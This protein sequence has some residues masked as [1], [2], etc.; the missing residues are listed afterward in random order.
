MVKS[1][2]NGVMALATSRTGK[3]EAARQVRA[4]SES[5]GKARKRR[6]RPL[7]LATQVFIGLFLGL[8]TGVFLGEAAAPLRLVGDAFLRLL[9]I[10]V[11]PYIV[12]VLITGLGRLTYNQV[13]K[14]AFGG[15]SVLLLLWAI[16]IIL[17][18]S[19]PLSFPDWPARSLFQRSSIEPVQ[20]V[21][22]LLLYIPS[23]PFFSL[24]NA[25]VPAIVVFSILIGLALIG[26]PQK[27]ALLEPLQAASETLTRV[28][29]FVA[30]LAPLGVFALI[31]S[32]AGTMRFEDLGRLQVFLVVIALLALIVAL[33][34]LPA[35][36]SS[37]TS[38]RYVDILRELRTPMITAFATGSSLVVLPLLAETCKRMVSEDKQITVTEDAA[39][40]A[41]SSVDILIPTF[42]SFP[43]MGALLVLSFAFFGGWHA[44]SP[45]PAADY[46]SGILAGLASMFG[47]PI[48]A[49]PFVL[50]L[51][52]LPRELFNVFMSIN[53]LTGRISTFTAVMHYATIALIGTYLL[54]GLARVRPWQLLRAVV[55]GVLLVAAVLFGMR[56]LYSDILIVPY[57]Q[58]DALKDLTFLG[59]P[60]QAVIH[61]TPPATTSELETGEPRHYSDIIDS[62]ILRVC[63]LSGNYPLSFF[64]DRGDL[65]GFDIEMAH[66]VAQRLSLELEFVPLVQLQE[67]V[68][69]L[70]SG[71]C[72][73][74]FNAVIMGLT[75]MESAAET[76]PFTTGTMAFIVPEEQREDF[77]TW[78]GVER[79]GSITVA[80]SAF[81]TIPRDV[82]A[83]MPNARA[84]RLSS[85]SEQ[86][87]Y[88]ATGGDGA[89]AFLDTAEEGS[90]W[91]ILYPRFTV[92]VPRPVLQ[93]PIVYVVPQNRPLLLRAMN[94]WLLIEGQIGGID[95]LLD[96]WIEGHTDQVEPPRWSIIRDVLHWVD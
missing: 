60:Q 35:L 84:K 51:L 39:E 48:L 54:R 31:A 46:P 66:R 16:G 86:T 64:N 77:A 82:L 13:K 92:V 27:D 40:D 47:G 29:G 62:G 25:I 71:Y 49:I 7:N 20:P 53:V 34:V 24:A 74:A 81:Q 85:L 17:I 58:D 30:K 56:T 89:D 15:G 5:V 65:V 33:W 38:L 95:Q 69:R 18:V 32:A 75:T 57:T 8:A 72:D 88:F 63:Y 50:D 19:L 22:L 55:V 96:Y 12:V 76:N 90:A 36:I 11:I 37:V 87:R 73:V 68:S 94:A 67:T 21:D 59:T 6:R 45:V 83:R 91:T 28:T 10:T 70:D 61:T 9:Q 4:V 79:L 23:N 43:T 78:E 93:V 14:L 44:G 42:F 41:A 2:A 3:L 1:M 80:T 52:G 26:V